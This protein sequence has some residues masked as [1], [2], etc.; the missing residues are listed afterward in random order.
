MGWNMYYDTWITY[1]FKGKLLWAPPPTVA[2]LV[3]I[4]LG[5]G[6]GHKFTDILHIFIYPNLILTLWGRLLYKADDLV[7]YTPQ[8]GEVW[9]KINTIFFCNSFPPT[10][11]A[12]DL[13]PMWETKGFWYW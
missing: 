6:G 3:L 12:Y 7:L 8:A 10:Y 1:H 5:G 4:D 13:E 9:A 2:E 11:Y